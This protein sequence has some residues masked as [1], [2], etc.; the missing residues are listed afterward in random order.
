[1][2]QK[3]LA[4]LKILNWGR[5]ITYMGLFFSSF[6]VFLYLTFP[7]ES[8]KNSLVAQIEG[9]TPVR[10]EIGELSPYRI[11]GVQFRDVVITR[12]GDTENTIARIEKGR[13]RIHI[14]PIFFGRLKGDIDLY[15]FG[16]GVAGQF[17]WK[18]AQFAL[19]ANFKNFDI[20]KVGAERQFKKYGEVRLTGTLGGNIELYVNNADRKLNRGLVRLEYENLKMI[21]TT[22]LGNKLPDLAFKSPAVVQLSLSNRF[23]RIDEW[24]LSSDNL[25]INASGRVTLRKKLQ[26]SRFNIRF[27]IK[28]SEALEDAFGSF[29]MLLPETDDKGYYN[30]TFSGTAN[31]PKFKKR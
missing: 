14:I 22:I 4:Q 29:A 10:I 18:G 21:N 12:D 15:S 13:L 31:N 8:L 6:F 27:G 3:L 11:T 17:I 30:F 5:V 24:N 25:E 19:G 1:M 9:K 16:G 26:N 23:L 7:Y 28:P 20:T 2:F